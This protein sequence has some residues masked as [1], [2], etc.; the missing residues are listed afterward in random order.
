MAIIWLCRLSVG[1]YA[2]AGKEVA[3]PRQN[4]GTCGEPM[5]F[6]SGYWRSVRARM[7]VLVTW[8]K[9]GRCKRCRFM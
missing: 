7:V 3:V 6:W 1:E 9:R 8:V 4:C 2:A 5:T